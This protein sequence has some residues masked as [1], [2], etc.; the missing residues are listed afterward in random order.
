MPKARWVI[1]ITVDPEVKFSSYVQMLHNC[2]EYAG[3]L[4]FSN[5]GY[6]EFELNCP[7]TCQSDPERWARTNA[8]RMRHFLIDAEAVRRDG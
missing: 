5:A 2:F 4:R 3:L 8:E 6:K 7:T 1:K